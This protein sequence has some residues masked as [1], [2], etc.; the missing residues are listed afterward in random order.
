M[1]PGA[2]G[3]CVLRPSPLTALEDDNEGDWVARGLLSSGDGSL[4]ASTLHW[5]LAL[6]SSWEGEGR[7]GGEEAC[8][9]PSGAVKNAIVFYLELFNS[10]V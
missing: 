2:T 3:R 9:I 10:L 5:S 7:G 1:I 6:L 4:V 8:R